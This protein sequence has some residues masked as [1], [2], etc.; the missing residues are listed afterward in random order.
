[1]KELIDLIEEFKCGA[2]RE[3]FSQEINM[4]ADYVFSQGCDPAEY[5]GFLLGVAWAMR[6]KQ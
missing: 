1:M 2:D 5:Q 3:K 6:T 4:A